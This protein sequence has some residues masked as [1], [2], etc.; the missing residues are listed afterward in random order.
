M[1]WDIMAVNSSRELQHLEE[2]ADDPQ[3]PLGTLSEVRNAIAQLFPSTDWSEPEYGLFADDS[4]TIEFDLGGGEDVR[5]L[6]ITVHR[7]DECVRALLKL[8]ELNH[9]DLVDSASGG[10]LSEKDLSK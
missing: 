9:W 8:A 3:I 10:T 4:G 7:N 2:L 5:I 6:W 1:S